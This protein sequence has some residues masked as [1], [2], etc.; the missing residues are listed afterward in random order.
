MPLS[1]H[2]QRLLEQMERAFYEEDPQFASAM[3]RPRAPMGRRTALAVIAGL[4]GIATI[5]AGLAA[6]L[7]LV[8]VAGFAILLAAGSLVLRP[9]NAAADPTS[10]PNAS[11]PSARPAKR[12]L[13]QRLED[14]WD[15]RRGEDR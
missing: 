3:Q 11:S 1:E 15:Q 14:R 5:V 10:G 8:G 13:S 12:S 4:A 7:P 9:R 6:Q 2:E